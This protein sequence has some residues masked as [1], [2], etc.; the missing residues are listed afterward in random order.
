ML[1]LNIKICFVYGWGS[2]RNVKVYADNRLHSKILAQGHYTLEIPDNTKELTFKLGLIYP[3]ETTVY[4]TPEDKLDKELFVG[5]YLHHRGM[6][7]ALYDSLKKDYLRSTKLNI[8]EYA[9]FG[10]DIYQQEFIQ[11]QNNKTSVLS[12]FISL[13]ILVFSV[14]QQQN[15]LASLAFMI[16]LSSTITSLVYFK[17]LCV[18]KRTYKTRT[19]ATMASFGLAVLFL[20]NS[21]NFLHW[22]ILMFTV[23]LY[24]FYLESLRVNVLQKNYHK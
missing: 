21:Y 7:W 2:L 13:V 15:E 17:D 19:L 23:L 3:Y 24:F 9:S 16:G 10:K 4:I 18:E 11:L 12:F 14:V 6:L 8:N 20:E 1:A 5:L 22:V